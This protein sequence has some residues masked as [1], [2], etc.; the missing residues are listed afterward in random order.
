MPPHP[1]AYPRTSK[2]PGKP[3]RPPALEGVVAWSKNHRRFFPK[4]FM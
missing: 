3:T 4:R 2:N 1:K